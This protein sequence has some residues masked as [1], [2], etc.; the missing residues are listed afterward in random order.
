[1]EP[2]RVVRGNPRRRPYGRHGSRQPG[3]IRGCAQ[4]SWKEIFKKKGLI[5]YNNGGWSRMGKVRIL[6]ILQTLQGKQGIIRNSRPKKKKKK[7]C[8]KEQMQL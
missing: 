3:L 2:R 1:M 4:P 7:V 5:E 6:I 8:V